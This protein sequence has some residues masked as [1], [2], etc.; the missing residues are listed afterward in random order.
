MTLH[1]GDVITLEQRGWETS[2]PVR[3]LITALVEPID[4]ADSYWMTPSPLRLEVAGVR[5]DANLLTTRE[6]A[7]RIAR[8]FVPQTGSRFS[9]RILFNHP[10]LPFEDIPEAVNR[11]NSFAEALPAQL[12][13]PPPANS[14]QFMIRI[15]PQILLEYQH[16]VGLLNVFFAL[17]LV[18]I[19]GLVLFFLVVIVALV[20][21]SERREVAMLQSRGAFDRQIILMRGVEALII[22]TVAALVAPFIAQQVLT[23]FAPVFTHIDQ[24]PLKLDSAPFLYAGITAVLALHCVD[25]NAAPD[26]TPATHSRWRQCF[27]GRKKPMVA[28]LLS[29]CGADCR[30]RGGSAAPHQHR[31][32][33]G[34]QSNGS[35]QGDPLLLLAPAVLF[36]ALGSLLLRLF[37][38]V[39][40]IIARIFAQRDGLRG[41]LAAWQVSREPAHHGR[42]AFLLVLAIGVGWF[43]TS[44]QAT[45][46]HSQFDQSYYRVGE[47]CAPD[48]TRYPELKWTVPV[49]KRII[50]RWMMSQTHLPLTGSKILISRPQS[51]CRVA[52]FWPVD[53]DSFTQVAHW[54]DDLGTL[55]LP[56]SP[57]IRA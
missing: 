45:V 26:F 21:R 43:A 30:G 49:P 20:R 23:V 14:I 24:L 22:C 42:I 8:D 48:R 39:A 28:T 41:A 36:I 33:A 16:N 54:R 10:I 47:R 52:L 13:L 6:S 56:A 37:P 34:A 46:E 9:W 12:T 4:P 35:L 55:S 53:P 57:D 19:G 7:L 11:L 5:A 15:S 44:F 27:A 25:R 2:K 29:G 3:T 17:L 1:V 51:A 50:R 32:A 18:Q 31:Y 40:E 38:A